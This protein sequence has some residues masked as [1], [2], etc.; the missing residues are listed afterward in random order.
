MVVRVQNTVH[1]VDTQLAKMVQDFARSEIDQHA[2][3]AVADKVH[4]ARI[5]E[6]I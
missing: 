4:G 1:F 2:G 3:R 5:F 6:A